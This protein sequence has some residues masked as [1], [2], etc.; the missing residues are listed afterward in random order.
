MQP[1]GELVAICRSAG[2]LFRCQNNHSL[3]HSV[4]VC[5]CAR[6]RAC[7]HLSE[8]VCVFAVMSELIW[9]FAVVADFLGSTSLL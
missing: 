7:V 8:Q 6:A 2:L 9:A 4:C 1:F 5:V 3:R